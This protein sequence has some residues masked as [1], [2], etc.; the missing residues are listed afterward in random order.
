MGPASSSLPG[1]QRGAPPSQVKGLNNGAQRKRRRSSAALGEA[2][3][4][5]WWEYHK[6]GFYDVRRALEINNV[7]GSS[8]FLVGRGRKEILLASKAVPYSLVKQRVLPCLQ[9]LMAENDAALQ[10]AA[11]LALGKVLR[12]EDASLVLKDIRELLSSGSGRVAKTATLS[13]GILGSPQAVRYLRSLLNDDVLGRR[14]MRSSRVP[15]EVRTCA[16]LSLGLINTAESAGLLMERIDNVRKDPGAVGVCAATVL[17]M[18]QG[19]P[20]Q[21]LIVSFLIQRLEDGRSDTRLRIASAAALGKLGDPTALGTLLRHAGDPREDDGVRQACI[22]AIGLLADLKDHQAVDYLIRYFEQGRDE[23][24]R[25]FALIALGR[26]SAGI[27]EDSTRAMDQ[28]VS[29]FFLRR[30]DKPRRSTDLPWT[31]LAAA[32]KGREQP[33]F[34]VEVIDLLSRIIHKSKDPS[35]LAATAISLSILTAVEVGPEIVQLLEESK[36]GTLESYLCLALGIMGEDAAIEPARHLVFQ[37]GLYPALRNRA[38]I[39]LGLLRDPDLVPGLIALLDESGSTYLARSA[40]MALG[41]IGDRSALEPLARI[42]EDSRKP[43][44]VRAGAAAALGFLCNKSARP[45]NA[46]LMENTHY[47]RLEESMTWILSLL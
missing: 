5:I 35:L 20:A 19:N 21:E 23:L 11:V 30:L 17:G 7:S 32:I 45:L 24:G 12:P 33:E 9:S 26:C 36:D 47:N 28:R 42:A 34:R 1:I 41:H 2:R 38:A 15:D 46:V 43:S 29:N 16:A 44:Q 4:E 14:L 40:A 18:M 22:I 27:V 3:W 25:C 37:K 8:G 6:E 13:M 39:S 10:E 31:A